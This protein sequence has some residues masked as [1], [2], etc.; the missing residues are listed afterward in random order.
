MS[1]E[2]GKTTMDVRNESYRGTAEFPVYEAD[3]VY[4]TEKV[5]HQMIYVILIRG[6]NRM[7]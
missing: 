5:P 1:T 3:F 2:C 7:N 4:H 6:Q